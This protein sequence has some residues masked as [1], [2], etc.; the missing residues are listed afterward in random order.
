MLTAVGVALGSA[1]V[2]AVAA[3]GALFGLHAGVTGPLAAD[4]RLMTWCGPLLATVLAVG[5]LVGRVPV[6]EI[7]V[8]V[9]AVFATALLPVLDWR[10]ALAGRSLLTAT[11][12]V[13]SSG[14]GEGAEFNRL[15]VA[16]VAGVLFAVVLRTVVARSDPS[17]STR[18]SVAAALTRHE[19]WVLTEAEE[20]WRADGSPT[21]L[22]EVLAAAALIRSARTR[23][24]ELIDRMPEVAAA[25]V[26]VVL[27]EADRVAGQL[28]AAVRTPASAPAPSL[29]RYT[30]QLDLLRAT[31][32]PTEVL[33][34]FDALGAGLHRARNAVQDGQRALSGN[35]GV[36]SGAATSNGVPP[37]GRTPLAEDL[38]AQLSPR[39]GLLRHA[40]RAAVAALVA[41]TTVAIWSAF[42]DLSYAAVLVPAL[43]AVLQPAVQ[44]TSSQA[45]QRTGLVV[46][47]AGVAALLATLVPAVVLVPLVLTG[48]VVAFPL[49][50]RH[51][52]LFTTALVGLVVVLREVGHDT[53]PVPVALGYVTASAIGA[54]IALAIA[55]LLVPTP[56]TDLAQRVRSTADSVRGLAATLAAPS[57]DVTAGIRSA[58]AAATRHTQD[59]LEGLERSDEPEELLA[60][61]R[62]AATSLD[63]LR[64]ELGRAA[65]GAGVATNGTLPAAVV[66]A[67]RTAHAALGP[68]PHAQRQFDTLAAQLTAL[69]DTPWPA[70]LSAAAITGHAIT[71]RQA[72]SR[73][74]QMS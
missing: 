34:L 16:A 13:V 63:L 46:L 20:V 19:P 12:L 36:R 70:A 22:G 37:L 23:L 29:D 65:L 56:S 73:V 15:V 69:R 59:L 64:Q 51:F 52:P 38:R 9:A 67:A 32:T 21:W 54:S 40:V 47:V 43:F 53:P 66:T 17:A 48:F 49:E 25:R 62:E 11:V 5:P 41:A 4:L 50:Q 24:V 42:F 31:Q 39:S 44:G 35:T 27:R 68:A 33:D 30:E 57:A 2:A 58:Y 7:P 72:L 8:V 55:Y 71:A 74:D 26:R 61:A 3:L 28:A 6:L 10:R 1:T 18:G 60:T 14:V 45:V